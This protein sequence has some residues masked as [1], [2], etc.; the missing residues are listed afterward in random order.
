MKNFLQ[1][2]SCALAGWCPLNRPTSRSDTKPATTS[3]SIRKFAARSIGH[4][5]RALLT[6]H[7]THRGL[8]DLLGCLFRS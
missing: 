6:E 3:L 1:G 7:T 2:T 4:A 5:F 8:D